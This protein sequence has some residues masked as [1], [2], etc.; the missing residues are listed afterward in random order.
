ML[1]LQHYE[2]RV[3]VILSITCNGDK[4]PPMMIIIDQP[5]KL[6]KKTI[7]LKKRKF[8]LLPAKFLGYNRYLY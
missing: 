7:K 3:Y 8:Y 5:I 2:N 4:L 6:M 1:K